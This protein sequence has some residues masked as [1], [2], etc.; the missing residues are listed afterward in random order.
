MCVMSM[1]MYIMCVYL[2]V[3][4]CESNMHSRGGSRKFTGE[5]GR[6]VQQLVKGCG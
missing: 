2:H 1:C 6:G 4:R 5:G 3:R